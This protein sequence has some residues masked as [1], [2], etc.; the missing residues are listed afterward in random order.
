M[1]D[2]STIG[3]QAA[4]ARAWILASLI[5]TRRV[6]AAVRTDHALRSAGRWAADVIRL[7]G[8]YRMTVNDTAIAVRATGGRL[9]RITRHWKLYEED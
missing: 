6:R 4:R 9:A 8:T 5:D 7:A 3:I 2:H 1:I